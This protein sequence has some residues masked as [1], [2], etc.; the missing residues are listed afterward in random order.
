VNAELKMMWKQTVVDYLKI[1]FL[2]KW[3]EKTHK[4][5]QSSYPVSRPRF[6]FSISKMTATHSTTAFNLLIYRVTEKSH[7]PVLRYLLKLAI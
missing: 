7:N 2:F 4:T 5:R 3:T 1:S 6:K